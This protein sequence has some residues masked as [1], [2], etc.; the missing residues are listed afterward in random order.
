MVMDEL[1][2]R[3]NVRLTDTKIKLE[4]AVELL[5]E[6]NKRC[7]LYGAADQVREKIDKFLADY[8]GGK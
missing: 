8:E 4:R 1:K 5:R 6:I 7:M 2:K 3:H